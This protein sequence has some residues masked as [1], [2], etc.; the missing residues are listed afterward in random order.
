M[1]NIMLKWKSKF[2]HGYYQG[3]CVGVLVMEYNL[4]VSGF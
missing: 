4:V 3:N 1:K 2:Y